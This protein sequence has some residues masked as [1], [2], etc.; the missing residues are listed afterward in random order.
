MGS[1]RGHSIGGGERHTGEI[2]MQ[3]H[4]YLT[5]RQELVPGS[6]LV[7]PS[8]EG[9]AFAAVM[10]TMFHLLTGLP[11]APLLPA[12]CFPQGTY[13]APKKILLLFVDS[14]GWSLWEQ[15]GGHLPGMRRFWHGGAV[16]PISALFPSTTAA[17]VATAFLGVLP[18][19]HALIEWILYLEEYDLTIET[20]QFSAL[21]ERPESLAGRFDPA[22]LLAE[23][24]TLLERFT[25]AGVPCSLYLSA[26]IAQS[27]FSRLVCPEGTIRPFRTIAEG[28]VNVAAELA[29]RPRVFACLYYD[30]IDGMAHH[31]GPGSAQ[32]IAQLHEFWQ[33]FDHVFGDDRLPS[34][35]LIVVIADHG[36]VPVDPRTTRYLNHDAPSL[37]ALLRRGRNGQPILPCGSARD[38]LLHIEPEHVTTAHAELSALL[39]DQALVLTADEVIAAGLFGAGPFSP[40]FRR[41]L[42][43]LLVLPKPGVTVW[44]DEPE[45]GYTMRFRGLHGGLSIEEMTTA[46]AA[47]TGEM[48]PGLHG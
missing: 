1:G 45:R 29:S 35:T 40:V 33:A 7:L 12:D 22:A 41:R 17:S 10:P 28:M 9:Y 39:R 6:G 16:T 38:L 44:W 21:G 47:L 36:H 8:Y 13:P 30:A 20:L 19:Q 23:R 24:R 37:R 32:H 5:V 48:E 3:R 14:L 11:A 34:D 18:A 2:I 43:D 27:S 4:G 26:S 25:A 42:G 46:F 31:Y 15:Y